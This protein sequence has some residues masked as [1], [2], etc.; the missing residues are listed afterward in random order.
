MAY[1]DG[2]YWRGRTDLLYYQYLHFMIRCLGPEAHS[3]IDVGSGNTP[4]LDWF[5]WIPKRMSV[6]IKQPYSSAVVT[7]IQGDILKLDLARHD[8]CTCLQVLEHVPDPGPFARRLLELGSLV[9]VSVPF[10]WPAGRTLGHVNDPVG[11]ADLEQWFGRKPNYHLRV[12]EPFQPECG[13]RLFALYDTANP[14][15]RF[16]KALR[17][18]RRP[19]SEPVA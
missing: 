7:G 3:I 16:G 12:H 15:R 14:K 4:Y 9:L 18:K 10:E 5:D 17:R 11:M 13:T 6:D 2:S 19:L 1:A 8:I